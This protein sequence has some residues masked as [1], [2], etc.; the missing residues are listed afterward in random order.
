MYNT[1]PGK[2]GGVVE[3][4]ADRG[5][6]W[7]DAKPYIA[8]NGYNTTINTVSSL[9]A[10]QA[11][12]GIS[13]GFINTVINLSAFQNQAMMFRFR[14]VT[15]NAGSST[16]WYIDDITLRRL[17]GAYNVAAVVSNMGVIAGLSD[18]VT[19]ISSVALPLS[20]GEFTAEKEG[21]T[22]ILNWSTLQEINA[23]EF[24]IERSND[25]MHFS[26]IGKL[27]A[28]GNTTQSTTYHF[29]DKSP[30]TGLNVYRVLQTD[31][32]GRSAYS[33]MRSL[34]F[35]ELAEP[36]VIAP[37]PFW[38]DIIVRVTGNNSPL[39]IKLMNSTGQLIKSLVM[40]KEVINISASNL[41][42][43][44]YYIQIT[45]SNI[46]TMKKVVKKK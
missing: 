38:Q 34:T 11:Y 23:D 32:E 28:A 29:T 43:G 8:M 42:A 22:A 36:V 17:P 25:G 16:G 6:S 44:V 46:N 4:S 10:K 7:F 15:D 24:V 45:G 13:G 37:N 19:A 21:S 5:T 14:Y 1:Q 40:K 2:D 3:L 20:W 9:S 18:T 33:P 31:K 26:V 12:S 35:D 30:V 41:P 39:T 27:S